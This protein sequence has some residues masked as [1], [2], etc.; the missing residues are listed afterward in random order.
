[1]TVEIGTGTVLDYQWDNPDEKEFADIARIDIPT[2][3]RD[4]GLRINSGDHIDI[5]F[6]NFWSHEGQYFVLDKPKA[7]TDDEGCDWPHPVIVPSK[8]IL[9]IDG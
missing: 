5:I 4:C 2:Y 7:R 3:E 1:M 8:R 9:E 6:F